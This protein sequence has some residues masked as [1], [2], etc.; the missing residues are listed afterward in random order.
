LPTPP[1]QKKKKRDREK[2]RKETR[3]LTENLVGRD[4]KFNCGKYSNTAFILHQRTFYHTFLY[5]G[6]WNDSQL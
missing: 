5:L 3:G 1:S 6:T 4:Y 2:E